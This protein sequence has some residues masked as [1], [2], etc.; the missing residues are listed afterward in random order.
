MPLQGAVKTPP[1]YKVHGFLP[2]PDVEGQTF[3]FSRNRRA[4]GVEARLGAGVG[5]GEVEMAGTK[6]ELGAG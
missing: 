2:A 6:A 4:V 3:S 5:A 1:G